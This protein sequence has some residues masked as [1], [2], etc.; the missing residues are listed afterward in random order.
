MT[1]RPQ[2]YPNLT[3]ALGKIYKDGGVQALY[4]GIAPTLVGML[5]YSTCYYFMYDKLKTSYCGAHKKKKLNRAELLLIGAISGESLS[6]YFIFYTSKLIKAPLELLMYLSFFE[7]GFMPDT[8]GIVAY[9]FLDSTH[10]FVDQN[11][12]DVAFFLIRKHD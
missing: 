2:D 7:R 5:P 8:D 9:Y 11:L 4:S 6:P 12:F 3:V 10:L 1:I